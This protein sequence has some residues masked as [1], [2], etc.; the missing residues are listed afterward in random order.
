MG[1]IQNLPSRL[2]EGPGVGDAR[3]GSMP[4]S[5]CVAAVKS[6]LSAQTRA[7]TPNPSLTGRG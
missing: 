7:P 1:T 4:L 5:A 6:L 2:R 3:R